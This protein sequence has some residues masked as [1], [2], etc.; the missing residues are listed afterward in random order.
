MGSSRTVKCESRDQGVRKSKVT[1]H[2]Q[3]PKIF[4]AF[5]SGEQ[6]SAAAVISATNDRSFF[7]DNLDIKVPHASIGG[8]GLD[9][10]AFHY[11]DG[12]DRAANCPRKYWHATADIQLGNG[13]NGEPG[14]GISLTP[15]PAQ[16]GVAFCAGSFK[17]AGANL[18][19]GYPIPPPEI[20]PAVFLDDINFAIGLNPTLIRGGG[21]LS[22]AELTK[23]SGTLLAVFARPWAPYTLTRADAGADLQDLAGRRFTSTSFALG[24][25]V[26]IH[27]P[28]VGD[29]N[30]AHG[31]AVYSYPDYVGVGAKVNVQLGI[32]VFDGSL[33][34][35]FNIRRRLFEVDASAH[36]CVRGFSIACGGGLIVASEKGAVACIK[37]GPLNPG[38]GVMINGHV[39]VWLPDGCKPSHYWSA[40]RSSFVRGRPA[41][42]IAQGPITFTVAK[43]ETAKSLQLRGIGG[44]PRV[45]VHGPGGQSLT[46]A[47]D[48][49]ASSGA[50]QAISSGTYS[51]TWLGVK[52][53]RAGRYTITL[54]PGSVPVSGV[55][56]TRSGYDSDFSGRVTG[57]GSRLTLHYD[58]RKRGGG[59][60][61]TFYEDGAGVM[62]PLATSTGGLGTVH[63][64]P[65]PG[66]AG[67]RTIVAR[68][69]V[70]GVPIRDQV[71]A[72]FHFGGTVRT[73]RP[74][75]VIVRR[76]GS[77]LLVSWPR[78]AGAVRYGVLVT[79]SGGSQQRYEL[80]AA[81]TLRIRGYPLTE[82]GRVSVSARGMLGDWGPTR[83]SR[84]FK[85][86][87]LAATV[88]VTRPFRSRR[89]EGL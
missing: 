3:L 21:T 89:H 8:I 31:G 14:A 23:I 27:V 29:L 28:G 49:A 75:K 61:V 2:V 73:G 88:L 22:A 30:I 54:L 82:G 32:F 46:V 35:Q 84:T 42:G 86:T 74:G 69:T 6:P 44:A 48:G 38:I 43:G 66:A 9:N 7:L 36:I 37:L 45:L 5:G 77:V 4:D 80:P 50:L 58:A 20:F 52:N 41:A 70:D 12:G 71:L 18:H 39:D 56:E 83:Q 33:G 51:T 15:P 85:A 59:Q 13:P 87:R 67:T 62:H 19:F 64:T 78:A 65:A 57:H 60:K 34:A 1:L 47:S 53:G 26:S 40:G 24:G 63:F 72:R 79:R 81:R 68:A 16:N 17:G 10:L 11:A 76:R 55:A 25:A